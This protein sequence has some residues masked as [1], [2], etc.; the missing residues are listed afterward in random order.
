MGEYVYVF[1][2]TSSDEASTKWSTFWSG[3]Y[4]IETKVGETA[5]RVRPVKG[6]FG[7]SHK[8]MTVQVDRMKPFKAQDPIITPPPNFTG[9]VLEADPHVEEYIHVPSKVSNDIKREN[10]KLDKDIIEDLYSK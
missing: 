9:K 4:S 8:P 2:P 10:N 6:K 5:Y 3:P 1:T 7:G